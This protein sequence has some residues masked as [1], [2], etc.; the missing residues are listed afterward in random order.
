MASRPRRFVLP[1][2]APGPSLPRCIALCVKGNGGSGVGGVSVIKF[3]FGGKGL[4]G[5]RVKQVSMGSRCSFT[6]MSHGGVGRALGL[7]QG[8]GVGNVGALVRR[9]G[10]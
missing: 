9:T 5:S 7:V 1:R 8:R 4:G 10:W 2:I 3:L 6:T